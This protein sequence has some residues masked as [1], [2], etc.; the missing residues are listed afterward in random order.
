MNIDQHFQTQAS[1]VGIRSS[2]LSR[3]EPAQPVMA[4]PLVALAAV[5]AAGFVTGFVAGAAG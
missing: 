5:G 4:T 2:H 3:P 1:L